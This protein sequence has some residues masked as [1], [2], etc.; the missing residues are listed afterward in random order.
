VS[1]GLRNRDALEAFLADVSNPDSPGY[2]HFLTQEEFNAMFAPTSAEEERV[3]AH[4]AASGLNV[5]DRSPNRL[6]VGAVGSVAALRRAFGVEIHNVALGGRL[7][8]AAI[9]EPSFPA[10]IAGYV[11]GVLG[12][13]DLS[14]MR[15]H[16]RPSG[17]V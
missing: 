4:L 8:Y 6:L 16:V 5:T 15:A 1:L 17:P 13:D 7:H 14:E 12:L 10:D 2:R 9:N 3:V 11:L